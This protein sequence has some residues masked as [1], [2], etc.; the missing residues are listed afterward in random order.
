MGGCSITSRTE[1]QV[2]TMSRPPGARAHDT[3]VA[4]T[5]SGAGTGQRVLRRHRDR[6]ARRRA[7]ANAIVVPGLGGV[8]PPSR[9]FLTSACPPVADAEPRRTLRRGP[10]IVPGTQSRANG[11]S[12][13]NNSLVI[14][15][16]C[17]PEMTSFQHEPC[18][19]G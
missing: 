19:R 16:R 14:A 4:K 5:S 11:I 17:L 13:A 15:P 7:M 3:F 18:P 6:P 1:R 12:P 9:G 8:L 2:A 10:V